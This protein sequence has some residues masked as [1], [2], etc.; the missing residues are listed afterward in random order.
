MSQN[1]KIASAAPTIGQVI[2][3]VKDVK[4]D[5][6]QAG[7]EAGAKAARESA[8]RRGYQAGYNDVI[9]REEQASPSYFKRYVLE[10]KSNE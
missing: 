6:Y 2:S 1:E 3:A 9:Q 5:S 10:E 8:W 7:Y 4:E